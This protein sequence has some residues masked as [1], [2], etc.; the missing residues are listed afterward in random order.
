MPFITPFGHNQTVA[1]QVWTV[2]HNL[3]TY[4]IVDVLVYD[5]GS[6]VKII[7]LDILFID[8]NTVEIHF[9]SNRTGQAR[10]V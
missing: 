6:L 10:L 1:A 8:M 9:S 7:P 4:P 3:N 5:N 2:N